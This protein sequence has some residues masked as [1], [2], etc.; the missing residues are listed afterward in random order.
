MPDPFF[1]QQ[2]GDQRIAE[3][4]VAA[5]KPRLDLPVAEAAVLDNAE[6]CRLATP[7]QQRVAVKDAGEDVVAEAGLFRVVQQRRLLEQVA[8]RPGEDKAEELRRPVIPVEAELVHVGDNPPA[9]QDRL[10]ADHPAPGAAKVVKALIYWRPAIALARLLRVEGRP[11]AARSLEFAD[12]LGNVP[13]PG[14]IAEG[15]IG[16]TGAAARAS[17]GNGELLHHRVAVARRTLAGPGVAP[18][19]AEEGFD[20]GRLGAC[21]ADI[22]P[23]GPVTYSEPQSSAP[24]IAL[25]GRPC[26]RS[27]QAGA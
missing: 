10:A 4:L 8:L 13:G 2:L 20:E 19:V 7:R 24:G 21:L 9:R 18:N 25:I 5:V 16:P 23:R 1:I 14:E 11:A 22:G 17:A 26:P 15:K 6:E 27:L 12:A 3:V